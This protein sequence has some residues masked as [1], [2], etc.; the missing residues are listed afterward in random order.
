MTLTFEGAYGKANRSARMHD[1]Y[2][3]L[4]AY[5]QILE[6]LQATYAPKI[7]M[8]E[9]DIR[10]LKNSSNIVDFWNSCEEFYSDED[11]ARAWLY[12]DNVEVK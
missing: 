11:I 10:A 5:N 3:G 1:G 12:P 4:V 2:V 7:K 6:Q 9:R 8:T